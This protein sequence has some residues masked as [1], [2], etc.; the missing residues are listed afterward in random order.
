MSHKLAIIVPCLFS[1]SDRDSNPLF[2]YLIPNLLEHKNDDSFVYH[3]YIGIDYNDNNFEPEWIKDFPFQFSIVRY[4]D[5]VKK[6]HLTRMWN[7]LFQYAYDDG[8]DYFYQCG[9]DIV[10]KEPYLRRLVDK[11]DQHPYKIGLTG[12]LNPINSRPIVTQAIVSRTHMKIFG[13]FFPEEIIN[14]YCDD[15][16]SLIYQ[17]NGLFETIPDLKLDNICVTRLKKS[18]QNRYQPIIDMRIIRSEI[19]KGLV[20]IQNY[21]DNNFQNFRINDSIL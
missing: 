3:I 4:S 16:I 15:W 18:N 11:I 8:C 14:W 5:N 2:K 13:Y 6:G 9:D 17:K 12:L 19:K 1:S 20:T 7:I 21:I 10:V